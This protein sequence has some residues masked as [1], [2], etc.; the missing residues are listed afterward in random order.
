MNKVMIG[1]IGRGW[2]LLLQLIPYII[3]IEQKRLRRNGGDRSEFGPRTKVKGEKFCCRCIC[4]KLHIL[5]SPTYLLSSLCI[6]SFLVAEC[7]WRPYVVASTSHFQAYKLRLQKVSSRTA[8]RWRSTLIITP[9]HLQF[10]NTISL[11]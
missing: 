11:Q 9:Q 1:E 7:G 3:V 4:P 2:L 6:L 5:I 8:P 10:T